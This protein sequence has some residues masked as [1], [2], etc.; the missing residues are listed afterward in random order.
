MMRWMFLID[1]TIVLL[2]QSYGGRG[3]RSSSPV[4][5]V[6]LVTVVTIQL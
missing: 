6:T 3:Y 1:A 2:R 5:R 4:R